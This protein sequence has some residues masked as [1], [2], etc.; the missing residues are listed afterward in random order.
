MGAADVPTLRLG[1]S[2]DEVRVVE[3]DPV[4]MHGDLWEYGPSWVRFDHDRV[5]DWHSSPL[6]AL[7]TG[8]KPAQR[9][10]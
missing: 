2:A 5:V 3:G 6:R 10:R 4:S 8:E 7:H 9:G 1:M